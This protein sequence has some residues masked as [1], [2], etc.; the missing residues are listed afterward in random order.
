[1][2]VAIPVTPFTPEDRIDL[3]ALGVITARMVDAGIPVVTPN[4]NTGEYYSL[5]HEERVECVRAVAA[6]AGTAAVL[7]GVGG[8]VEAAVDEARIA[9]DLGAHAIMV[10]QPVHPY[11][12]GE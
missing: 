3:D 11:I 2:V 10:H 5:G 9:R 8:P 6:S 1:G 4:G 12:T 7:A